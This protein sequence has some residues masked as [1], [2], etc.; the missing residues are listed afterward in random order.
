MAEAV[1]VLQRWP[2]E[3]VEAA[4][5]LLARA[6]GHTPMDHARR[7]RACRGIAAERIDPRTAQALA[8]ALSGAGTAAAAAPSDLIPQ[9]PA[10]VHA[11][12]IDPRPKEG[13][14]CQVAMTGEPDVLPWKRIVMVLPALWVQS[15]TVRSGPAPKKQGMLKKAASMSPTGMAMKA[16]KA[17]RP[18]TGGDKTVE[19]ARPMVVIVCAKPL[20]RIHAFADRLD[21][22]V[23]GRHMSQ[24]LANFHT[25]LGALRSRTRPDLPSRPL[26]D[27]YLA[28]RPLPPWLHVGDN[29]DL[30]QTA[31]W[32]FF[33]GELAR[34]KR[35]KE[36]GT[37][38]GPP[39]GAASGSTADLRARYGQTFPTGNV[40]FEKGETSR[41]MYIIQ[42]GGVRITIWSEG[43]ERT[44]ARFGPGDFFGEMAVL[45]GEPRSASAQVEG[46]SKMLV[47]DPQSF[48]ELIRGNQDVA[49]RMVKKMA[50]RLAR[51]NHKIENL[52]E[53]DP[54]VRVL[55]ELIEVGER[56]GMERG[57]A[58]SVTLTANDIVTH[59]GL[60][61]ATV[62]GVLEQLQRAKLIQ[63]RDRV[64]LLAPIDK[65]KAMREKRREA[66]R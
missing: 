33:R 21:Y 53:L 16:M 45:T 39:E 35:A 22:S 15:R 13:L 54:I 47:F 28:N 23:L 20:M 6:L 34:R 44:V 62:D 24:G 26:L 41:D 38:G 64:M 5:G 61:L 11:R 43:Q 18:T 32:L 65:L 59:I 31:R 66:A 19:S 9:L 56:D 46:D 63:R 55:T 58:V 50:E 4:A 3:N 10:A 2:V 42:S 27:A 40:L 8:K 14:A 25:L 51:A 7:L 60:P 48:A 36:A 17:A 52:L 29:N 57:N 1:V 37:T 12:R 30:L 49:V